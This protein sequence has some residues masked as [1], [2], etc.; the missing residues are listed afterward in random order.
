MKITC[1]TTVPSPTILDA[2]CRIRKEFGIDLNLK[3]YYTYQI[4]HE[5]V[6][7]AIV[8]QDLKTA[9]AVLIDIRGTGRANEI[10]CSALRDECNISL[11][12]M[13]PFS[14]LFEVTRLGALSGKKIMEKAKEDR[15]TQKKS[16]TGKLPKP[17]EEKKTASGNET[18]DWGMEMVLGPA[19]T[20]L[21]RG[22]TENYSTALSYWRHGGGENYYQLF[23]FLLKKYLNCPGLPD[24]KP[25]EIYPDMGIYHPE[26]GYFTDRAEYFRV[27]GFSPDRPSIGI[28]MHGGMHL[29][30]NIPALKGLLLAFADCNVIPTYATPENN[31]RSMETFFMD[32][33]YAVVDAVINLKWFRINGG[34]MGGDPEVTTGLLNKMNIPVFAPVCM[35]SQDLEAWEEDIA[36]ISPI[37]SIMSVIWPE[38]DGCIEPIPICGIGSVTIDGHEAKEV[39]AIPDRIDRIAG[40]I[41]NWIRLKKLKNAD[42]KV[43]VMIYNYPPGEAN[44]GGAAYLDVFKS[45]RV[46]LEALKGR[47][48]TVSLPE[49][50]LH[51]LFEERALVNSGTWF[52]KRRTAENSFTW[53]SRDYLDFFMSLPSDVRQEVTSCW[54]PPPGEVMALDGKFLVPG[55]EF[56]NIFVGLQPAR[57]P[58]DE[59]DVA[60]ASHDKTKPPHHQYL[61]YYRWL[62]TVWKADCV[63]HVGTHGLAEFTK[64]K[65]IG[66]SAKCFPDILIGNMPHLYFYIVENTSEATI[67][68]RRLYGTLV[69][70]NTPPFST[71][72]LYEQYIELGDLVDEYEEAHRLGQDIREERIQ[73]KIFALARELNF[74]TGSI[75]KIHEQLY[76]MKRSVIPQGLH[77]IGEC[78]NQEAKKRYIEFLLRFDREGNR[79]LNRLIAESRGIPYDEALRNKE[80]YAGMLSQ[81]DRTCADIVNALVDESMDAALVCSGL[82]GETLTLAGNTL[83]TGLI[84]ARDYA[85]NTAEMTNFIRGLEM[86]FIEPRVGGDVIRKP[87]VLPTGSNVLQFDPS[88]IP[89]QVAFERGAEIAKNTID[90]YLEREG[91]HPERVGIV[92][93][94]FETSNSG[95]ETIGQILTYIGIRVVRKRGSWAPE[96]KIIPLEELGRPRID[97]HLSIC[98]F[99]RD[100]FPNLMTQ[101]NNAFAMISALD[102]PD[103]MNYVKKHTIEN[104]THL[105]DRVGNGLMD[106]KTAKKL[107]S[108]RLFGPRPGEYGTRMLAL[109]EDSV[110]K[111][112][113]DLAEVY[114]ASMSHI[115]TDNIHGQSSEELYKTNIRSVEIISQI[116]DRNDREIVDLDHYF[117]FIGGLNK[118]VEAVSGTRP[119]L[120]V[121][122]TTKEVV[123]T[124]DVRDVV[125]RGT[126]TR[127]LNPKWI[128]E[129]LK[130]EYHGAQQIDERVYNTLGLAATTHAVDNWIWSSIAERFVFDEEMRRRIMENNKFSAVRIVERLM[131]AEQRGYW[132][133]TEE[134]KEGLRQAYLEMEGTIEG[135][136]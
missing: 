64:G 75:P 1:I 74:D 128:D 4:E 115:Y 116:R 36:G 44:I 3:L 10:T 21:T 99:F 108:G 49:K 31:I 51:L 107:A 17:P 50:E 47:G 48:Y 101:L 70:Y 68:K 53:D 62:E 119:M 110:W 37:M 77:V 89:T 136:N 39:V 14:N 82:T 55:I 43:A 131:E 97:C 95:G 69:S 33:G 104:L 79:S 120:M 94:G 41:K 124:E 59:S 91:R 85:D 35:F 84:L 73:E 32:N 25:P 80:N 78:Y 111:E 72:D 122:D 132:E 13:G 61:A 118:A 103:E 54:G 98:G 42:K 40:R 76:E 86:E 81:V 28:M 8:I 7:E 16:V 90:K 96:L 126:R 60:K 2:A 112:E 65:E 24:P 100:M 83:E 29:D 123:S 20:P 93:W 19:I 127:L 106:E 133:A 88:K 130:H 66:M 46:L 125:T 11:N 109:M 56:G 121:S 30:Q 71:S 9:D 92:L 6:D 12:M 135:Y 22:D 57:P 134:E 117:E 129:M 114:I 23:I 105:D 67:A 87:E 113:K 52:D 102:E 15:K 18:R 5:Q 27:A 26:H 63:L 45:V 58:L 34:P 38:L